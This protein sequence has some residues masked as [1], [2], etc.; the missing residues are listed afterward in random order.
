MITAKMIA[1]RLKMAEVKKMP[2]KAPV[3]TVLLP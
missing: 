3:F 2:V 1:I